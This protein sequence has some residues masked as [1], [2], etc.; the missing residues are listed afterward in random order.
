MIT[1]ENNQIARDGEVIGQI[2]DGIAWMKAKQAPRI[3][4]QIRAAAGIDGLKFE[5]LDAAGEDAPMT[6]T[7]I[8][9]RGESRKVAEAT[10]ISALT[11]ESVKRSKEIMIPTF[12]T[13]GFGEPGTEYF[14]RCFVNHY[15]ND[16][17]SAF[18]KERE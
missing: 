14:R 12:D 17:Y 8:K 3:I 7:E 6:A 18:M 4:G 10:S 16:N 11:I 15:G 1:I 13:T 5:V 2:V 9:E